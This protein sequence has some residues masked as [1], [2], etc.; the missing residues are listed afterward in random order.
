MPWATSSGMLAMAETLAPSPHRQPQPERGRWLQIRMAAG[1]GWM[2]TVLRVGMRKSSSGFPCERCKQPTIKG[3]E[4][5]RTDSFY[6][7]SY[8][9]WR[10]LYFCMNCVRGGWRYVPRPAHWGGRR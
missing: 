4:V 10:S 5:A 3:E 7:E 6:S 9:G 8:G 1:D 2:S